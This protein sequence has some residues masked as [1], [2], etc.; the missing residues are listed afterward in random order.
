MRELWIPKMS[1]QLSV[2]F[3]AHVVTIWKQI[4]QWNPEESELLL[5]LKGLSSHAYLANM[6]ETVSHIGLKNHNQENMWYRNL[7]SSWREEA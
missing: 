3:L 7:A 2:F 6:F 4:I 5:V 1:S